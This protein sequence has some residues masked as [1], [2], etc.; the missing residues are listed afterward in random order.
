MY[1]QQGEHTL[2][3]SYFERA[4]QVNENALD[5]I[6]NMALCQQG[7]KS[8]KAAKNNYQIVKKR[9]SQYP[10]IDY[11]LA[12]C[13]IHLK[14]YHE[15]I[16]ILSDLVDQNCDHFDIRHQLGCAY[17][18]I[19]DTKTALEHFDVAY[20]LEPFNT[21]NCHNIAVIHFH[22]GDLESALQHWFQIIT[23][24]NQ[25]VD[26][27]YNIG[28]CYQY[29][30]RFDDAK[31]FFNQ[32]LSIEPNHFNTI[33][34]MGTL[35]LKQGNQKEAIRYY[36]HAQQ[37]QPNHAEINFL[38]AALENKTDS[39]D[40]CPEEYVKNLFNQ[41]A[42]SYDD[43]LTKALKYKGH[44]VLQ[45]II[46]VHLE[47]KINQ[48]DKIL[49]F[50]CG[51]GMAGERLKPWSKQLIGLD[52][53]ENMLQVAKKLNIYDQLICENIYTYLPDQS[54]FDIIYAA[55]VLP[56]FGDIKRL[57]ALL[58]DG[59]TTNGCFICT[60]EIADHISSFCLSP[61]GRFKHHIE[62]I[63]KTAIACSFNIIHQSQAVIR[64]EQNQPTEGA[65]F[66]FQRSN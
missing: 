45:N 65:I 3:L 60:V 61:S 48:W 18:G 63:K 42:A 10:D 15:A 16:D 66:I 59:L 19:E 37:L 50:G 62:Y 55:D 58:Y 43:H 56:Y 31:N 39:Y 30:A 38:L 24:D 12:Q 64:H 8:F 32:L 21:E 57:F 13:H 2:A 9:D 44:D 6:F 40:E 1:Y 26:A 20:T 29:L 17:L 4:H 28:V 23:K 46:E 33:F 34:N 53:S 27:L 51:T 22:N 47:P 25:H 5:P 7:Q 14:E 52:C 36:K 54:P 41:Y 35:Y 49:D 11:H